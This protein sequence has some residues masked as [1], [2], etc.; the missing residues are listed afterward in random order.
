MNYTIRQLLN[1]IPAERGY[2]LAEEPAIY[3]IF[4]DNSDLGDILKKIP[5]PQEVLDATRNT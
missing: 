4:P 5:M 3:Q 1:I 2:R